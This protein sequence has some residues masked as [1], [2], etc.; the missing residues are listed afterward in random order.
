MK[1]VV[2]ITAAVVCGSLITFITLGLFFL[3]PA[4]PPITV[5]VRPPS[6]PF[7]SWQDYN[8]AGCLYHIT[9]EEFAKMPAHLT[10]NGTI[11]IRAPG[12]LTFSAVDI[13]G[14]DSFG[15]VIELDPQERK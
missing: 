12:P 1:A 7:V 15:P 14:R 2:E 10:V 4:P 11:V 9:A 3:R 8:D 13:E 5:N 6:P